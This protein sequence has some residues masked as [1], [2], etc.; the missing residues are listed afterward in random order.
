MLDKLSD[1][2]SS[3]SAFSTNFT[4]LVFIV[5]DFASPIKLGVTFESDL[6]LI[7]SGIN[8]L[9]SPPYLSAS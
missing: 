8:L 5:S 9:F 6:A 7:P 1:T 4:A 2:H 3:A